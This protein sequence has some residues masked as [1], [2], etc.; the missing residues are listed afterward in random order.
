[1]VM[2]Y[3]TSL[4]EV[5]SRGDAEL[6]RD[7][8]DP[9]CTHSLVMTESALAMIDRLQN[10]LWISSSDWICLWFLWHTLAASR[11]IHIKY[12]FYFLFYFYLIMFIYHLLKTIKWIKGLLEK[13]ATCSTNIPYQRHLEICIGKMLSIYTSLPHWN[14]QCMFDF[15]KACASVIWRQYS[16]NCMASRSPPRQSDWVDFFLLISWRLFLWDPSHPLPP[17]PPVWFMLRFCFG[18]LLWETNI[19]WLFSFLSRLYLRINNHLL[20][21]Q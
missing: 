2:N 5:A 14:T 4:S 17:A 19:H 13:C 21:Q 7:H 8:C 12:I 1:M 6:V 11:Q 18:L 20:T 10:A 9:N 3:I 16:V 15:G